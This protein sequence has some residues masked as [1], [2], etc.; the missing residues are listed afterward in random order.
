M[1]RHTHQTIKE[2][3]W[4]G[5]HYRDHFRDPRRPADKP[6]YGR[7]QWFRQASAPSFGLWAVAAQHW[8]RARESRVSL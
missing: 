1:R 3:Y 5:T 4:S 8:I 2:C 6:P 7:N